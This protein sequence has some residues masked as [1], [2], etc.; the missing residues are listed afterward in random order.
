MRVVENQFGADESRIPP[1]WPG[2]VSRGARGRPRQ[3]CPPRSAVHDNGERARG[4]NAAAT[5]ASIPVSPPL[6]SV[7]T[8]RG[9]GQ[10]AE[11]LSRDGDYGCLYDRLSCIS[12]PFVTVRNEN[13]SGPDIFVATIAILQNMTA[14]FLHKALLEA[15]VSETTA[16]RAVEELELVRSNEMATKHDLAE[17][18]TEL[19]TDIARLEPRMDAMAKDLTQ[20]KT[21]IARLE[22]RMDAM[23][24]KE[25]L[26]QLEI[27]MLR[28]GTAFAGIIIAAI[29]LMLTFVVNFITPL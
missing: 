9:T 8:W 1:P 20:L 11:S 13:M 21:D 19:K 6:H 5:V 4:Q 29:G 7:F 26:A 18:K 16:E 27:R 22:P 2:Q 25:K 10:R 28:W 15:N 12:L 17:L 23:V 24:T 14:T 3:S